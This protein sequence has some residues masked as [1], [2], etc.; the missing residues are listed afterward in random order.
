VAKAHWW[1]LRPYRIGDR[2]RDG[3][4]REWVLIRTELANIPFP[5]RPEINQRTAVLRSADDD[6]LR[7]PV[8]Q[9]RTNG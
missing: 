5:G 9:L 2:F 6:E 7:L 3:D 4:G 1:T 8:R